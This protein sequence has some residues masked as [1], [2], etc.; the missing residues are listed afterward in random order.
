MTATTLRR[1]ILG[2]VAVNMAAEVGA[3]NWVECVVNF[4][5]T[6]SSTEPHKPYNHAHSPKQV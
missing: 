1:E 2:G 6:S 5:Q 3:T 4:N